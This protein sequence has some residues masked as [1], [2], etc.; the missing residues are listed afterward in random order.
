MKKNFLLLSLLFVFS[1]SINAQDNPNSNIEPKTNSIV[2]ADVGMLLLSPPH[3]YFKNKNNKHN[4]N[5]KDE[6]IT[7]AF[8]FSY[9]KIINNHLSFEIGISTFIHINYNG[10]FPPPTTTTFTLEPRVALRYYFFS[11]TSPVIG[12]YS[13][14]D[15]IG[16]YLS[17]FLGYNYSINSEWVRGVQRFNGGLTMGYQWIISDTDIYCDVALGMLFGA[18]FTEYDIQPYFDS[19]GSLFSIGYR[20]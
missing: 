9:E 3:S 10:S 8:P 5:N 7:L 2:K 20:F 1:T 11:I 17:P 4:N 6:E 19:A 18:V 15:P 12:V 16:L 13:D 14:P